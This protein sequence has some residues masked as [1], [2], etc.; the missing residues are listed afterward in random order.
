MYNVVTFFSIYFLNNKCYFTY[1]N[2]FFSGSLNVDDG[3]SRSLFT[4]GSVASK[5][6][7]MVISTKDTGKVFFSPY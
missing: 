7:G 5:W 4:N 3:E 1:S 2:D 6:Y